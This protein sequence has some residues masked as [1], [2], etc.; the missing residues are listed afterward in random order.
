MR[1]FFVEFEFKSDLTNYY[2]FPLF[3]NAD[4]LTNAEVS[5]K[6]VQTAL[7]QHYTLIRRTKVRPIFEKINAE[8]MYPLYQPGLA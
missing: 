3:L 1:K 4:N 6:T 8:Y 7:E 5:A 2:W